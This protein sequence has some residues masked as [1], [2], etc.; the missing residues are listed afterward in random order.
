MTRRTG[1]SRV[2]VAVLALAF[3]VTAVVAV[4][5]PTAAQTATPFVQPSV[6]QIAVTGATP[7]DTVTVTGSTGTVSAQVDALGSALFRDLAQAATY[8][9]TVGGTTSTVTT[10]DETPPPQSFYDGQT[11]VEGFQYI[12]TRDG[13]TLSANVTL[14]GPIENG[15][16]PTVV[17]Y[18]GYDPSN[19]TAS[20]EE[21]LGL[22][23]TGD[24]P[25]FVPLVS[26]ALCKP[27]AQPSSVIAAGLGYAVVSVNIR[28]TGCSGGAFDLFEPLQSLDGYDVIE[29]VAAQP[30][31]LHHHVGMVGLSYPGITQ[32]YVAA[33]NPPS[34]AAITPQSVISDTYRGVAYPGGIYNNGFAD[35][36]I[37]RVLDKA[38]PYGQGWEQTVVDGG[39]TQ[40]AANQRL[41]LQ[42]RDVV[43]IGRTL[44]FDDASLRYTSPVEFYDQVRVPTLLT[45]QWQDEQT[46]PYF[47][48][49]LDRFTNAPVFKAI[50]SNGNHPDGYGAPWSS[51]WLE[52]LEIYVAERK[53]VLPDNAWLLTPLISQQVFGTVQTP[54]GNRF[55]STSSLEQARARFEAEP[56]IQIWF[57]S[58]GDVSFQP[59]APDGRY[60]KGFD[61]WPPT[62]QAQTLYLRDGGKLS[63]WNAWWGGGSSRYSPDVAESQR[64]TFAGSDA[65]LWNAR[66]TYD[67]PAPQSGSALTFDSDVFWGTTTFAGSASFDTWISSTAA[68]TDL[69][70]TLSEIRPDGTEVYIQSGWLRASH[71]ALD[72]ARST[73]LRPEHTHQAADYQ[74]LTPGQPTFV[75]LQ[76][77]PFAH[78]V[79]FGSKLRVT[80]DAPGASRARWKFETIN[81]PGQVNTIF[82]SASRP[83][84]LVLPVVSGVDVPFFGT[85]CGALRAQPCRPAAPRAR[86]L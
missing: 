85:S 53:P 5:G 20:I 43:T 22:E 30:W 59:G 21:L 80:I 7:G 6:G 8:D 55:T 70:V 49:D 69:E 15:P 83:S 2:G 13:T 14:P 84:K 57:E 63:P 3:S 36:W 39:D 23:P 38:Q 41:R 71:R 64:T 34:L 48:N 27:P 42:N 54:D 37:A 40:C 16:Y 31:V 76:I 10:L 45:G 17:E 50:L 75:R 52:F 65:E 51:R 73:A 46:G 28:G 74:L 4:A 86:P 79:R 44:E 68:D 81:Q 35:E 78:T 29:T 67:W 82:H 24:C 25:F 33:T 11:L 77:M 1:R 62:A 26:G 58:G 12:T 56:R 18:S 60:V 19:P 66:A 47:A 72:P 61:Q 9:V 32:I